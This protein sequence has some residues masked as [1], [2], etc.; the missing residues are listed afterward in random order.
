MLIFDIFLTK[1][2]YKAGV[3]LVFISMLGFVN[4]LMFV[5]AKICTGTFV[6]FL[7]LD[8]IL[9]F[10]KKPRI[11]ARRITSEKFSLGE[12]NP[13][14]I[15]IE[16]DYDLK[17]QLTVIDEAPVEFQER[18]IRFEIAPEDN[19]SYT[20]SYNLRPLQRGNYVFGRVLIYANT[21]I[22]LVQ[23]RFAFH[24]NEEIKVY[25]SIMHMRDTEF[26]VM[27]RSNLPTGTKK[28]RRAGHHFEFEEIRDYVQG[29]DIR[30]INWKAT[31][32]KNNL[33]INVFQ[34]QKS[35]PVYLLI[36]KGRTMYM[37]F[38]GLTLLDYAIN[39]SLAIANILLKK[40]D[41]AGLISFEKGISTL[42]KADSRRT[43]LKQILEHLYNE[44]TAFAE[45]NYYD[46]YAAL[47]TTNFSTQS[48]TLFYQL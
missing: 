39:S 16:Q 11:S 42:L 2:V 47:K 7:L 33:M 34:E 14:T 1:R 27:S 17:L 46:L 3:A 22:G 48:I 6:L 9:L 30:K 18:N 24:Q 20:V 43:Q 25:P 40:S 29:D 45:P 4:P 38:N 5:L 28:V 36:N 44:K 10:I 35:Q 23:R 12:Q 41:K 37:P 26:K 32:R 31:A 19:T 8:G 15:Q 21:F 13:V